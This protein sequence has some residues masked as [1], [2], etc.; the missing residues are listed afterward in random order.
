MDER[1]A[2]VLGVRFDE[3]AC[4]SLSEKTGVFWFHG[5]NEPTAFGL[6]VFAFKYLQK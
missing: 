4:D 3:G 2:R 6:G 5:L 1:Q